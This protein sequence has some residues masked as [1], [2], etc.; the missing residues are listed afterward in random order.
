MIFM[1]ELI[2]V[3]RARF[4]E[5][6]GKKARPLL[7]APKP[8]DHVYRSCRLSP[9]MLNTGTEVSPSQVARKVV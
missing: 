9:A 3:M 5:S 7:T 4:Y 2:K 8:E 6:L 1:Q